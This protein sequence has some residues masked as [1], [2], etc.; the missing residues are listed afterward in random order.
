MDTLAAIGT[1]TAVGTAA[2]AEF[3]ATARILGTSTAVRTERAAGPT[4]AR[5]RTGIAGNANN[6]RTPAMVETP[7]KY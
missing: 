3:L 4:A 6:S 2:T 1:P 5:E 7:E